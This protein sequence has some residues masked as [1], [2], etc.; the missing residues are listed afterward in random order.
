MSKLYIGVGHKSRSGKDTICSI[1]HQAYPAETRV[2]GFADA[3]KAYCR[4]VHKMKRKDGPLLQ[5]V[6]LQL[7][8]QVN[9]DI[10]INALRYAAEDAPEPIILIPDMRF[11]NEA[12]FVRDNGGWVVRVDRFDENWQPV[13]TTDRDPNHIS[14]TALNAWPHWD[15]VI[16][17]RNGHL[18]L[19][20]ESVLDWFERVYDDWQ[21][22][23]ALNVI[24]E[25]AA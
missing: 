18:E 25:D 8:Q 21:K 22:R 10:W 23:V 2:M 24:R 1:I 11:E 17:N 14:E 9:E 13:V 5:R 12:M 4:V 19:L 16:T 6:G 3:L 15:A 20:R 7:R